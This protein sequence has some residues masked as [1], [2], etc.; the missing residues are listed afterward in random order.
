[1]KLMIHDDDCGAFVDQFGRCHRCRF[2]PDMQSTG[3]VDVSDDELENLRLAGRTF[4]T[5]GRLPVLSNGEANNTT[6]SKGSED[7]E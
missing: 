6:K 1:M 5:L 2:Y 4:L 7:N 3:F